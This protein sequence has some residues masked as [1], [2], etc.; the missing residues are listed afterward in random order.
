[1]RYRVTIPSVQGFGSRVH[2]RILALGYV[3]RDRPDIARFSRERGYH[4]QY[5]YGWIKG[6]L[7]RSG[8]L[9]RRAGD[10]GVTPAW[11][12]FGQQEVALALAGFAATQVTSIPSARGGPGRPRAPLPSGP[13]QGSPRRTPPPPLRV[14]DF[15]RFR[16][17]TEQLSHVQA[18]FEGVFRAF[19]DRY[20]W[21]DADGTVLSCNGPEGQG[22]VAGRSLGELFPAKPAG[23]LNQALLRTLRT[24]SLATHE[25]TAHEAGEARHF[26]ARFVPLGDTPSRRRQVLLIIRDITERKRLEDQL[27][28]RDRAYVSLLGNRSSMAYRCRNDERWTMELVSDGCHALTGY[29]A[30]DLTGNRV[31]AFADLIHPEDRQ[32]AWE[33][34]QACLQARVPCSSEYRIVTAGGE[35][36]WVWDQAH[37]VYA[38]SGGLLAVEGLVTDITPRKRAEEIAATLQAVGRRM[39]G[40]LDVAEATDII[41][42]AVPGLFRVRRSVLFRLDP[43]TGLLRCVAAA[44]EDDARQ[45]IGKTREP[46][47][48]PAGKAM[49]DRRPVAS[50][51]VLTDPAIALADWPRGDW[52]TLA[53]P[54]TAQDRVLGALALWDS[55]GRAFSDA[56]TRLLSAF[57]DQAALAL[58]NAERYRA[59]RDLADRLQTV[60]RLNRLVSS[61]LDQDEVLRAIAQAAADLMGVPLALFYLPDEAAEMLSIR[62]VSEGAPAR[63]LPSAIL[64]FKVD[65]GPSAAV[66]VAGRRAPLH[67]PDVFSDE[68]IVHREWWRAHGLT[69]F[70]GLPILRGGALLGVLV[71]CSPQPFRLDASDQQLLDSLLAQAAEAIRNA[72]LFAASESA[73]QAAEALAEIEG[74]LSETLD[75]EVVAQRITDRVRTLLSAQSSA[76]YRLEA[77]AGHLVGLTG[78]GDVGPAFRPGI[79]MPRGNGA[80]GLAVERGEPVATPNVLADERITLTAEVRAR[81]EAAPYRAV[82]AVPLA[83]HDSTIGALSVADA[84]GSRFDAEDIHLAQAFA[85]HAALALENARLY[86]QATGARTQAIR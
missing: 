85:A 64:R 24:N 44:G 34:C 45:W 2:E 76:V 32:R 70:L 27:R 5:I 52:S 77:D 31:V 56:E 29:G 37:G 86:R 62:A 22:A 63:E 30:S 9:E 83:I 7:P 80:V 82:L 59:S 12:M 41:A 55:A 33:Q 16:E 26:E 21:L 15:A 36:K 40:T 18:Q 28:E 43:E 84:E 13:L 73:R 58:Q 8:H 54:L 72:R 46:G 3:K 65:S 79:V 67:I 71:L 53:V 74:L 14:L 38:P 66:W 49:A 17:L 61:T 10:L 6:R 39:V 81:I 47:Q 1:M 20:L 78:S 23:H 50:Q 4:A 11:L 69:S 57:A 75:P 51:N 68:R 25:Y 48:G 60:N 19:P 42:T 35:E